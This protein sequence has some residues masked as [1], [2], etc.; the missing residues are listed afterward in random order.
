MPETLGTNKIKT[1]P[2]L[3]KKGK[4]THD[5]LRKSFIGNTRVAFE[6]AV[7]LY[8]KTNCKIYITSDHGTAL[9]EKGYYF[10]A[11][12]HPNIDCL[13]NVPWFEVKNIKV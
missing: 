10:H 3:I 7:D 4:I 9:G 12:N 8:K 2:D 1:I 6:G 11:R 5:Y 13:V